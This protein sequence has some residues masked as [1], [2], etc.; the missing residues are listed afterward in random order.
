ML[1]SEED[2]IPKPYEFLVADVSLKQSSQAQTASLRLTLP[3]VY[4]GEIPEVMPWQ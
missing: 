4:S 2:F 1:T 3:G